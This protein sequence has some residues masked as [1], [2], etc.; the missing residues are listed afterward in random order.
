MTVANKGNVKSVVYSHLTH[1]PGVSDAGS[2]QG[3]ILKRGIQDTKDS[4]IR[5]KLESTGMLFGGNWVERSHSL[6]S[7]YPP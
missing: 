2:I 5:L 7:L 1:Y 3:G 6:N 4:W